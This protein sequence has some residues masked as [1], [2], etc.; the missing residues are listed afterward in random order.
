MLVFN[1]VKKLKEHLSTP[2]QNK[3]SIGF[4][5]TMGA[6]HNGHISLIQ[7]AFQENDITV[8]SI[9]VNPMQFNNKND[10]EKYPRD[11]EKDIHML[12]NS[13]CDIVF[14]PSVKEMYPE[15]IKSKY[16][17][18]SLENVMEGKYRPG[19]FNGVAVVVKRLFDIV[20]PNL[21]YFGEKDFQQ[22]AVIKKL[23]EIE[24]LDIKIIGCPIIRENDGLA[25]SSRNTRL[26][27]NERREAPFVYKTLLEAKDQL[28]NNT[29]V[30]D[31]KK[32][33]IKQFDRNPNFRLEYFE[34]AEPKDLKP[35]HIIQKH[36][37]ARLFIAAYLGEIRLIDNLEI[38]S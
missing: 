19:H 18:G 35:V 28:L 37:K 5:P 1:T 23:K 30:E 22:L 21:A 24:N 10:L 36:D 6:L 7:Q 25:M 13:G 3:K 31:V 4:V 26:N 12:E 27:K 11:V 2:R 9:F 34:I 38:Y 14:N 16:N 29:T 33:V 15:P 32:F 17:F 20:E 8:C